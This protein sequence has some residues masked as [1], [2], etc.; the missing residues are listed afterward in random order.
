MSIFPRQR[1]G[2]SGRRKSAKGGRLAVLDG[3]RILAALM[4]VFHH[5]IG[6]GGGTK[7]EISA[8]GKP[9]EQV[10]H[11]ASAPAAYLWTGICLFFVISGFVI[12]MSSWGR[13]VGDFVR[14]RVIRLY[15]AYWFAVLLTTAV[16]TMW[17][18]VRQ[19]LPSEQVLANLTMFHVGLGIPNVDAV[20]WTLWAELRFYLLFAI[21]V[22]QGVTY[23]RIVAF[24]SIWTVAGI[25]AASTKW[26]VLEF[27]AM[28]DVSSFFVAGLALYLVHRYGPNLM[29]FGIVGISWILSVLYTIQHQ[30]D[31]N[32]VLGRPELPTW[33]AVLLTTLSYLVITAVAMGWGSRIQWRWLTFAGA[34][35]YPLYLLH[36][37][38]GWTA[39]RALYDHGTKPWTAVAIVITG[40]LVASWLVHRLIEKPLTPRLKTGMTRSI[41]QLRAAEPLPPQ[42]AP[43]PAPAPGVLETV[44][45]PWATAF[46]PRDTHPPRQHTPDSY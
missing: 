21:V 33:P 34:L 12:C 2:S 20:Y 19:P 46:T 4:V 40:M 31:V 8:W 44:T 42:P 37:A 16:V 5:Y 32:T 29:L 36:E 23:R 6:Y 15:P 26:P 27:F 14:S 39:L 28:S 24:C 45:T 1:P 11:R 35:T 17:P 3:L 43:Q 18:L 10:F 30:H 9:A 22:W 41:D 7:P 38:M 13:P 25:V